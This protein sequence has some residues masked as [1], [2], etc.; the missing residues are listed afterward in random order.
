MSWEY[1]DKIDKNLLYTYAKGLTKENQIK[2]SRQL[3]DITN[4]TDNDLL[5]NKNYYIAEKWKEV[6][7]YLMW[8]VF[9]YVLKCETYEQ[10]EQCVTK[11][12]LDKYNLLYLFE[13]RR[14]YIGVY[15]INE[16]YLNIADED[17]EDVKVVLEILY[18]RYE[19]FEQLECFIRHGTKTNSC[20]P[21]YNVKKCKKAITN[22]SEILMKMPA[23]KSLIKK[24][25]KEMKGNIEDD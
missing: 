24:Y 6:A 14:F 19:F 1:L 9:R 11:E 5:E 13:K 23:N 18:N 8:F 17:L 15:G 4:Q 25:I 21:K 7:Y 2:L 10:A 12:L 3:F 16:I 22:Y 20:K